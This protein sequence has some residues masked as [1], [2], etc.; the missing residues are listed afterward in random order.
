MY[1]NVKSS[2]QASEQLFRSIFENAQIGISFF[3]IDGHAVFSNR[4]VHQMLGY[5]A[6]ELS[7]IEKWDEIVH[8]DERAF[9]AKRYA[10]LI[11]GTL[12]TYEREQR[13]IR[14]DGRCVVTDAKFQLLRDADGKPQYVVG[15]MEDITGKQAQSAGDRNRLAKHMEMLLEST[16]RAFTVSICRESCTFIN[17]ATYEWIGYRPEEALGLN[18]HELI[19]QSQA[20]RLGLP[21]QMNALSTARSRRAR[22]AASTWKLSGDGMAAWSRM[23]YSSFPIREG[24]TITGAVVTVVDITDRKQAEEKVAGEGAALPFHLRECPDRDQH[25][26]NRASVSILT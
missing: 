12:D 16:T 18:V 4:A 19:H 25:I 24:E 21:H 14:R 10:E 22:A 23:E 13:F 6:E 9:G 20:G 15:L 5:T 1:P 3:N 26:W 2:A 7:H 8:P 11:E 17:R